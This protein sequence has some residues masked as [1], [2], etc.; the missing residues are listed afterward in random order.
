MSPVDNTSQER[1]WKTVKYIFAQL[2]QLSNKHELHQH[3]FHEK[4]SR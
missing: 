4:K 3:E 1:Q 2:K